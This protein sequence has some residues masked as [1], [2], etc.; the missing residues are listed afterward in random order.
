MRRSGGN[1]LGR[2]SR[3]SLTGTPSLKRD[4]LYVDGSYDVKTF[5][6][7]LRVNNAQ[8]SLHT[9]GSITKSTEDTSITLRV[10]PRIEHLEELG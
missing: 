3:S 5:V 7:S 10:P 1:P 8:S 4:K 6:E 9:V 2:M